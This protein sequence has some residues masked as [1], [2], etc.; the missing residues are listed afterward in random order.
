MPITEQDVLR[1]DISVLHVVL[2]RMGQGISDVRMLQPG[3]EL[4][5]ALEPL[6]I[7]AR[8][9]SCGQQLHDHLAATSSC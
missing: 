8:G 7:H 9:Q 3:G 5:L 6:A 2:M 1:F 4:N